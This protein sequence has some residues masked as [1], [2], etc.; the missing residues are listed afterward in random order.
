VWRDERHFTIRLL[1]GKYLKLFYLGLL[2]FGSL[3]TQIWLK[4]AIKQ[5]LG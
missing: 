5:R 2:R 1:R 3:S 4:G